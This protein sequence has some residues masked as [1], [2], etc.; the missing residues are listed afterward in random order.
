MSFGHKTKKQHVDE[1]L[2]KYNAL[3]KKLGLAPIGTKSTRST[4]KVI[5]STK[6]TLLS[7]KTDTQYRNPD[8]PSTSDK[9]VYSNGK[10]D[11]ALAFE[12]GQETQTTIDA[13][14]EKASCTAPL[15]SKG[16]Y[17]YVTPKTNANEIGRK[18]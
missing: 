14:K 12:R 16:A 15:Y 3:M 7:T 18:I 9:V 2:K 4:K 10:T 17:Q 5:R 11:F 8:L 13:I 6:R 1:E